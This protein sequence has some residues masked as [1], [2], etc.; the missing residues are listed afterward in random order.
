MA[1][2]VVAQSVVP[3][4][5]RLEL[6]RVLAS[7]DF[8]AS[9]QLTNFLEYIVSESLA[10]RSDS[11]KERNVARSALGRGTDF[12]PRLDCVVRVTAGKLR[13]TL[14]RYYALQGAADGLCIEVPK[15][16]YCPV[17]RQRKAGRPPH[18]EPAMPIEAAGSP[19]GS[20]GRPVVAVVPLKSF[21]GG[22]RERFVAD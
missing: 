7:P 3:S 16:S 13:R 2:S 12:D 15:G 6:S 11:L 21:T 9:R 17:F 19:K 22:L 1:T 18:D 14:E 10:G 8:V 4:E 5:T 20:G